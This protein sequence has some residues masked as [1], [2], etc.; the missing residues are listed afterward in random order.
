MVDI[1][2]WSN[3]NCVYDGVG[4]ENTHGPCL[5]AYNQQF[6]SGGW[7]GWGGFSRGSE[8]GEEACC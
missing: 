3:G 7:G 8:G 2:Y 6:I 1:W 4:E 5:C